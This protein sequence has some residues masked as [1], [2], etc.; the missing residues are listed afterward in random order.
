MTHISY[1]C[2]K[3]RARQTIT[4]EATAVGKLKECID[5]DFAGAVTLV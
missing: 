4:T 3:K 2:N 5:D 1:E